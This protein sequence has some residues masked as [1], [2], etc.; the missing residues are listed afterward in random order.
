[1]KKLKYF[2]TFTGIGAFEQAVKN[3]GLN[4]DCVGYSEIDPYA[5]K[6]FE[7]NHP[8]HKNYG[9]IKNMISW[10][11]DYLS[12][13][14]KIPDIIPDFD[15]LVG[16]F[17]CQDLSIAKKNREGLKGDRSGLFYQMIRMIEV[18]K[19]KYVLIENVA[20]MKKEDRDIITQELSKAM[21]QR[22]E[23]IMI[24]AA[25]VT[26]QQRKRLFWCNWKVDQPEDRGIYLRDVLEYGA[27]TEREKSLCITKNYR[28][29]P[30]NRY[31]YKSTKQ[32]VFETPHRIGDIGSK[33]QSSR[34]YSVNGKSVCLQAAKGDRSS[35]GLY[36]TA[37]LD[38]PHRIAEIGNRNRSGKVSQGKGIYSVNAKSLAIDHNAHKIGL[39]GDDIMKLNITLPGWTKAELAEAV[40]KGILVVRKLTPVE[41]ERLQGFPDGYT[42]GVSNTRRY[43]GI[44]NAFC[45][46]VI[47]HIIKSLVK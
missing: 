35:T 19:P 4:W 7:K 13:E 47:E 5:V 37:P 14:N 44:G 12:F 9:D 20:S 29:D 33:T 41:C 3:T 45:V 40:E 11:T 38:K 31:L 21:G 10:K 26:A 18:K 43:M 30:L 25:L 34:L 42:E 2:S 1:M 36:L 27:F 46:P 8:G 22:I 39:T 24:N 15:L 16:G 28:A 23:P 6:V 32:L 17:P